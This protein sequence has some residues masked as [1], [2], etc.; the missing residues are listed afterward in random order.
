[1][2]TVIV[3]NQILHYGGDSRKRILRKMRW[4]FNSES[5]DVHRFSLPNEP[6]TD[7][8]RTFAVNSYPTANVFIEASRTVEV[9]LQ[10]ESNPNKAVSFIVP[11]FIAL[12]LDNSARAKDFDLAS[13]HSTA[14]RNNNDP[15]WSWADDTHIWII[16]D[17]DKKVFVYNLS[18][19][20]EDTDKT[21]TLMTEDDQSDDY[22]ND[23]HG[24]WGN[25]EY[26]WILD[27]DWETLFAYSKED[28]SYDSSVNIKTRNSFNGE[29]VWC[30]GNDT[31]IFIKDDTS[32][33]N[34][35]YAFNMTTA[36]AD[37]FDASL[38]PS[39]A[40]SDAYDSDA[41][42]EVALDDDNGDIISGY[43]KNGLLYLLDQTDDKFYAYSTD[44]DG[45]YIHSRINDWPL[46]TKN[47]DSEGVAISGDYVYVIN[48]GSDDQV[49][50]YRVD[51]WDSIKV[52]RLESDD[53]S[54]PVDVHIA[55]SLDND[56]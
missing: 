3:E 16:D 8:S 22:N 48:G 29:S 15:K 23:P 55:V 46:A 5:L 56:D 37:G 10:S 34:T 2:T 54:D 4:A 26:I 7:R 31:H 47:E 35:L 6:S 52:A 25:D 32:N 33:D 36:S 11:R 17:T 42:I 1:M 13:G 53:D 40:P 50:V 30:I 20:E 51:I 43:F 12:P 45:D 9:T 21:I 44:D 14:I 27:T 19:G 41:N 24:I 49:Y 18:T 28:G 38:N 39:T